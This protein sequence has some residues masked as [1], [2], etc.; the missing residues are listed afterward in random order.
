MLV[1]YADVYVLDA[2]LEHGH[3]K[4]GYGKLYHNMHL[5]LDEDS[6]MLKLQDG[7]C[8]NA[9]SAEVLDV[10]YSLKEILRLAGFSYS[11]IAKTAEPIETLDG[12]S[13]VDIGRFGHKDLSIEH[14]ISGKLY[15]EAV[16]F[17]GVLDGEVVSLDSPR[18]EVIINMEKVTEDNAAELAARIRKAIDKAEQEQTY[19]TDR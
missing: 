14:Y 16:D 4:S 8:I 6:F 18:R 5:D 13:T 19:D 11:F 9:V 12:V 1:Q 15:A 7:A 3:H 10:P 2:D 17:D